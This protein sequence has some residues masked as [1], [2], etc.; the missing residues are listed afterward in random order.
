MKEIHTKRGLRRH[1]ILMLAAAGAL[2]CSGTMVAE[3]VSTATPASVTQQVAQRTVGGVVV[4]ENGTPIVGANVIEKGQSNGVATDVHGR[5]SLRVRGE[6]LTISYVG[7]EPQE[8]A[9]RGTNMRIVLKENAEV[10]DEVVVV[11]Y[12]TQ[13]KVNV[14]GAVSTVDVEKTLDAKPQMDVAKALQGAVPGLTILNTQGGINEQPSIQ[15]RGVGTLSNSEVSNPLIIVD[16]VP[17]DD[18]SM[19][20]GADIATVSVLKDAA[21]TSIYGSRAAFGVILITTKAGTKEDKFTVNYSNNFA[22]STPTTLPEYAD[23]PSQLEA[24]LE[25]NNRAGSA[26]ELFGM[27]MDTMLPYAQAW[28]EQNGHKKR[29]YG[30][31]RP[32]VS[33]DNVGDYYVDPTSGATMYYADWDVNDIMYKDW[34]P[35]QSHNVNVQGTSGRTTYYLSFGY[36]RKDG[37]LNFNTDQVKRY[38]VSANI[39]S[40]VTDWLQIGTR[41]SYSKRNYTRPNTRRSIYE[42]MWRWGSFFEPLGTIDGVDMRNTIS[43]LK[44]AGDAE[45]SF[46]NTRVTG[47]LK[48]TP[49]KGLTVN[50]DFTYK[51]RNIFVD[52]VGLPVEGHNSWGGDPT[53]IS[54]FASDS[55]LQQQS[56]LENGYALNVYA[57]YEF[58]LNKKHNFNIMLGG[59]AE[60]EDYTWHRSRRNDLL[61]YD[62][63]EFN[64]A[65]G[66]QTIEGRHVHSA[67]AGYFGRI[68]YNFNDIWLL[69]LNGRYDGSSSFPEDDRWAFFASGSVGYRFTQ[70]KYFDNLRHIV[71]NGKLRA[72]YGEIGNEAV[73]ENMFISTIGLVDDVYWLN[74]DGTMMMMYDL[75]SLVS[76]SLTWERIRTL[77]LGIDLSFLS[78]ELN[79]SFDW[80]QRKTLDMLAPGVTL[81]GVLGATAPYANEGSLRTRG[82]EL[83]ASWSHRFG[84]F[85]V[86]VNGNIGDYKTVV[87]EWNNPTGALDEYFTGKVY[88]DVYGFETDRF[89]TKDDFTYDANGN[90]TGYAP[91][92][93]DQSG[94]ESEN[95]VYGPGDIK[96]VDRNNDGVIDGGKGTKNDMGDLTVIGNTT[97]RYQYGFRLGGSWRGIDIDLYFQGVG[98]WQQW[99]TGAFAIPFSRGADGIYAHQMDY[100]TEDN[101]DAFYPRYYPGCGAAGTVPNVAAGKYNFYPQSRY[102]VDRSYLRFKNLTVGYTIPQEFTRQWKVEKLRFYIAA[103]NLCE[104]IN[105]SYVPIDPEIDTSDSSTPNNNGT[106]GRVAPMQRTISFGLQLTL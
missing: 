43:Y 65:T 101:Q 71:N 52:T 13:K 86:Y 88:G 90:I 68:N 62:Q 56:E 102:M 3:P 69:E 45:T 5:F 77:D 60:G 39:S 59:N 70:E 76:S 26:P 67:T 106:W 63:P 25:L 91:G 11:G 4:D 37:A 34:S 81:P 44:Q 47:F 17:V 53:P 1:R 28:Q 2:L 12:G 64:L 73:G 55:Y 78:N 99:S 23:V 57:N 21:S 92:V 54:A 22:W 89:F 61:N 79:F 41:I 94:L 49:F 31:M 66:T 84:E 93:A 58:T 35:S 8:V 105:N 85:D 6:A 18:L 10:L 48:L 20:N 38:N 19:I 40:D 74:S 72:S 82:W 75:P 32:F 42:Y 96:F 29:G 14:T 83:T 97:P 33:M 9:A 46:N 50:A 30:E 36:S 100:W 98:K 16:G 80:Y 103:E 87:T 104:L 15:I 7:Y 24:L 51:V 27:Y 95:F